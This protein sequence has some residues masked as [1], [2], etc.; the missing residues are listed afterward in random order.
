MMV[1]GHQMAM[2][3]KINRKSLNG[4]AEM[5]NQDSGVKI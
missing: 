4:I 3:K 1:M 2:E 5:P